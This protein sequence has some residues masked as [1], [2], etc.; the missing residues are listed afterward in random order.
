MTASK[1]STK[2]DSAIREHSDL[3]AR[4]RS[5]EMVVSRFYAQ[6]TERG[7]EVDKCVLV[8][9]VPDGAETYFGTVIRQDGRIFEFDLAL[10]DS[11]ASDWEEKTG[12]FLREF[13]RA[14]KSKPWM[15]EVVAYRM[16]MEER[17]EGARSS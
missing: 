2:V 7:C 11:S 16:F 9:L 17:K 12:D 8:K 4:F 15:P 13:E 6:L 1:N 5:G 14:Q 3:N 10:T